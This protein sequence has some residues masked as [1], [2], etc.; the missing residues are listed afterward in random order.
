MSEPPQNCLLRFIRAAWIEI[1]EI[2]DR[3]KQQ[4]A[5]HERKFMRYGLNPVDYVRLGESLMVEER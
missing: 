3:D 1:F 5:Y 2:F 4:T